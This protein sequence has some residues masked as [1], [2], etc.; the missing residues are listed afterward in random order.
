M[1]NLSANHI[2]Y[3]FSKSFKAL[4]DSNQC[5]SAE[6]GLGFAHKNG[7]TFF[8]SAL[9]KFKSGG[10]LLHPREARNL[11][12]Q[13]SDCRLECRTDHVAVLAQSALEGLTTGHPSF[14]ARSSLSASQIRASVVV[15]VVR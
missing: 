7:P 10:G 3:P 5:G 11:R 14:S 4:T 9:L 8:R 13:I 6:Q 12:S 1:Y 15:S 2:L